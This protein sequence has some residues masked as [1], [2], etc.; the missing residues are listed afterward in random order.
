MTALRLS[1]GTEKVNMFEV[2]AKGNICIVAIN[3]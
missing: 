3:Y 2:Y 1:A